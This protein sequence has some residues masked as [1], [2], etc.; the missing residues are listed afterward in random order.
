MDTDVDDFEIV[1]EEDKKKK[2]PKKLDINTRLDELEEKLEKL[3]QTSPENIDEL[4]HRILELEDLQMLLELENIRIKEYFA[5]R[6]ETPIPSSASDLA[7]LVKRVEKLEQ[8]LGETKVAVGPMVKGSGEDVYKKVDEAF[9]LVENEIGKMKDIIY[10][11]I[12]KDIN[13][14][15]IRL[16]QLENKFS[17][18]L[19]EIEEKISQLD[20]IIHESPKILTPKGLEKY[21]E[22]IKIMRDELDKDMAK[23]KENSK[24]VS[25]FL[26]ALKLIDEK[27]EEADIHTEKI[28][29]AIDKMKALEQRVKNEIEKLSDLSIRMDKKTLEIDEK[30]EKIYHT[31]AE[32]EST[33]KSF[34]ERLKDNLSEI[35]DLKQNIETKLSELSDKIS[36]VE[37]VEDRIKERNEAMLSIERKMD[38]LMSAS[39]RKHQDIISID[40][41]VKEREKNILENVENIKNIKSEIDKKI[42]LN[43]EKLSARIEK[44]EALRDNISAQME[45]LNNKIAEV[46]NLVISAE[47]KIATE[48]GLKEELEEKIK[49]VEETKQK[50]EPLE[51]RIAELNSKIDSQI[52][53]VKDVI[54]GRLSTE[55]DK[56]KID[57]LY[58]QL[59]DI[60]REI[61]QL[62]NKVGSPAVK[63]LKL[64]EHLEDLI[65]KH[66]TEIVLKNLE[67]FAETLDKKLPQF[68]T[69]EEIEKLKKEIR[70]GLKDPSE[71]IKRIDKLE[72]QLE[73][74]IKNMY[75]GKSTIP[76]IVE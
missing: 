21:L 50:I 40:K 13:K 9:K 8:K 55:E 59:S 24:K 46:N 4:K 41:S 5:Q 74:L 1:E 29:S 51:G 25:S 12:K 56:K 11:E 71:T 42:K 17:N 22:K 64:D 6:G 73:L 28:T 39:M 34:E 31:Q 20:D 23:I 66:S 76:V 2:K 61:N 7:K 33:A 18:S 47:N 44:I 43:D 3:E 19:K 67:K 15:A 32:V 10:T 53:S 27:M 63:E 68:V 52:S 38:E 35:S 26:E 30:L 37:R 72:T 70:T 36:S 62:K 60:Q 69:Q 75:Q 58:K 48:S 54:K 16:D 49:L 65:K 45:T 57:S 14:Q